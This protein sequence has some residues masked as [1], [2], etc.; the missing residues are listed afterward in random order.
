MLLL[1]IEN[2]ITPEAKEY[3]T[4]FEMDESHVIAMDITTIN[5][6]II[7]KLQ[8][9]V[10]KLRIFSSSELHQWKVKDKQFRSPYL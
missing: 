6:K 4:V 5:N 1:K 7:R 9:C 3:G 10:F 8:M 2:T